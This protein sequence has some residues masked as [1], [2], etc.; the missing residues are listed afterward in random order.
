MMDERETRLLVSLLRDSRVLSLAVLVEGAPL[1]GMVPFVAHDDLSGALVHVSALARHSRGLAPGAPI[2]VLVHAHD[3]GAGDARQLARVSL[4]GEARPLERGGDDESRA[5]ARYL[6]RFPQSENIF[7][8][9]DFRL[10]ELGFARGRLVGGFA[11]A[12]NLTV[13]TLREAARR[14]A[15]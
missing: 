14:V 7:A 3:D 12:V 10:V 9:G 5:R 4:E 1:V 11:E 15:G 13:E 6:A 8:L 2:G